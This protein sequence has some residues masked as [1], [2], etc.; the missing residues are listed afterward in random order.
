MRTVAAAAAG[1][2]LAT[3]LTA[4]GVAKTDTATSAC[5]VGNIPTLTKGTLT[6]ATDSPAYDP[7]FSNNTPSNGK[8][9]ESAVAYAIAKKLGFAPANVKWVKEAFNNSYAPGP[10]TFD[11]DVNQISITPARAKAVDFSTGY[12]STTQAIIALKGSAAAKDSTLAGLKA[13]KLGAQTAT[14]SLTAIRNDVQPTQTPAVYGTNDAAVQALKNK[15]I[16]G[17]VVDLPT[18]FYLQ[19]V[20]LPNAV[21]VGQFVPSGAGDQF[22]AL[23]QKH[24]PLTKCVSEAIASLKSD[25]SLAKIQNE[26]LSTKVNVPFLK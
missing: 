19:A 7:W 11:F 8:G 26:W 4:C 5:K 25:G 23:L 20:E 15:Q 22:G 9:F 24:N 18:A 12:Y 21:I 2:L 3:G 13:L 10:K 16:D 1:L 17:L 14:T 6:V